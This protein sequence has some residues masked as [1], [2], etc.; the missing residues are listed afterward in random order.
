MSI[1]ILEL[2]AVL[3]G[4]RHFRTQLKNQSQSVSVFGQFHGSG[5]HSKTGRYPLPS[6]LQ[7]DMGASPVLP[8]LEHSPRPMAYTREAQHTGRRPFQ[9]KQVSLHGVDTTHRHCPSCSRSVGLSDDRSFSNENEQSSS[10]V[11]VSSA[12]SESA[13]SER[14]GR[15]MGRHK[16]LR[17]P[18]DPSHSG[19]AEQG[20]DGQGSP[21]SDRTLLAQPSMVSNSTRVI[22][23]PPQEAPRVGSPPLAPIRASLPQLP[24]F[25]QAS[26]LETIGCILRAKEFSEDAIS[27][28][29]L[30]HQS[31]WSV[32]QTWCRKEG[33]HPVFAT[34][35]KLVDF[36]N[37]LFIE[38][39]LSVSAIK[40][41]KSTL[42]TSLRK[43]GCWENIWDDTCTT[44][45]RTMSVA[46][47][48]V[49]VQT[50]PWFSELLWGSHLNQWIGPL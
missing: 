23:R 14:L 45:L 3:L 11:H 19:S 29:T 31:K 26:R 36:L 34:L 9:I 5:L 50:F 8:S 15:I 10:T 47:P 37:H 32:Y 18:S 44:A 40:G 33:V 28:L 42:A 48:R 21:M 30:A 38:R 22:D 41:Y 24:F 49:K 46:R 39:K 2:K 25:L 16:C 12:G 13:C 20:D 27:C 4:V 6:S 1:N 35:P 7:N 17:I 43:I